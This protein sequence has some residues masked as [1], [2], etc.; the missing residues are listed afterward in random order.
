MTISKRILLVVSSRGARLSRVRSQPRS[1]RGRLAA[2]A[3]AE[4]RAARFSALSVWPRAQHLET[5][6]R[7]GASAFPNPD[8]SC[9][10]ASVVPGEGATRALTT[11]GPLNRLRC[12]NGK[13]ATAEAWPRLPPRL[14]WASQSGSPSSRLAS[15]RFTGATGQGTGRRGRRAGGDRLWHHVVR[16]VQADG[17]E[18]RDV[19]RAVRQRALPPSGGRQIAGDVGDYENGRHP[20][21]AQLPLLQK[22]QTRAHRERRQ[23]RRGHRRH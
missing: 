14:L 9:R 22:R 17:P 1:H 15:D 12:A 7:W 8:S 3:A 13:T 4:V 18:D 6:K 5:S 21:R 16:T 19:E 10:K 2:A 20:Q 23:G 11:S